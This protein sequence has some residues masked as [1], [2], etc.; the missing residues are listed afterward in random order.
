MKCG[1]FEFHRLADGKKQTEDGFLAGPA[2]TFDG[3]AVGGSDFADDRQPQA[4]AA[5]S[6]MAG[7]AEQLLEDWCR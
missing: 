1:G 4:A 2:F 5:G 3:S 6:G 7:N